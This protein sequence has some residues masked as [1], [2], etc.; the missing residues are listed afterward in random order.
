M[1][2]PCFRKGTR[3]SSTPLTGSLAYVLARLPNQTLGF[4]SASRTTLILSVEPARYITN[5]LPLIGALSV[6]SISMKSFIFR[7][8]SS[9]SA[10]HYGVF[11]SVQLLRVLKN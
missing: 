9:A 1:S 4:L 3:L 11:L 5:V 10:L 2:R 8:A 7:K 6:G